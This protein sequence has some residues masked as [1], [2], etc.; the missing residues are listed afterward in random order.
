M[1]VKESVSSSAGLSLDE[2]TS[3]LALILDLDWR[4]SE[5]NPSGGGGSDSLQRIM[6]AILVFVNAYK[7]IQLQND[8]VVLDTHPDST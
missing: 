7:L 1:E 3:V 5:L 2:A 8:I 4:C 6:E